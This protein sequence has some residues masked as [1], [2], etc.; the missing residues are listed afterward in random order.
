M[1]SWE[2]ATRQHGERLPAR[3]LLCSHKYTQA[4]VNWLGCLAYPYKVF[5]QNKSGWRGQS[6]WRVP[7]A[8][9]VHI[10]EHEHTPQPERPLAASAW[11]LGAVAYRLLVQ[12]GRLR[13]CNPLRHGW[14]WFCGVLDE[15]SDAYNMKYFPSP[16][17]ADWMEI[18]GH[19]SVYR[20][21]AAA[22][23][24]DRRSG[25]EG[26]GWTPSNCLKSLD[27]RPAWRATHWSTST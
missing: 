2:D 19:P 11:A 3:T 5:P 20:A 26:D 17:D 23:A 22:A 9:L 18:K 8:I 21:T 7:A 16:K 4:A 1:S 12:V 6:W 10:H 15:I 24:C 27:S 13:R 25:D 14:D